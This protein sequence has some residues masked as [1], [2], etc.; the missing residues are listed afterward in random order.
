MSHPGNISKQWFRILSGMLLLTVA[1]VCAVLTVGCAKNHVPLVYNSLSENTLPVVNAPTVCLVTF[2]DKRPV[3]A[4][5]KRS[6][7][8][9]FTTESDIRGWFSQALGTEIAR[10]GIIVTKASSEAEAAKSNA[11]YIVLG[12]VDEIWLVEKHVAE[13]TVRMSATL[14]V[15]SGS[16]TLVNKNFTGTMSRHLVGPSGPQNLLGDI[17]AELTVPMARAV[18]DKVQR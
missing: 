7:D 16:R 4:I 12:S 10:S 9:E 11:K 6:D 3:T 13:S 17:A 2:T 1:L 18:H 5:G 8:T 15:K 14:M